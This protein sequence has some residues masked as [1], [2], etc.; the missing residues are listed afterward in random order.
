METYSC[1]NKCCLLKIKQYDRNSSFTSTQNRKAGA[2]IY[3]PKTDKALLVQS[4]G[5]LWGIP[6]GTMKYGESERQCAVREVKEETGLDISPENFTRAL[7]INQCALYFYLEMDE[8]DIN[9]QGH[10]T[11]N[12]ANGIGWI[13]LDCLQKCIENGNMTLNQ[14][15]RIIFE[16]FKSREFKHPTFI[17]VKRKSRPHGKA[18]AG[19]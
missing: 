12:D 18:V 10:I 19:S 11:D 1:P 3:D 7:R 16:R 5:H 8:C 4:R 9:V 6:K 17:V 14:H 15:C 13:K 2:F